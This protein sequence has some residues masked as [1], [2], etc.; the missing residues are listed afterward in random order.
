MTMPNR[1]LDRLLNRLS[2]K[3]HNPW[4]MLALGI[5]VGF[6]ALTLVFKLSKP[7]IK[8]ACVYIL[9]SDQDKGSGRQ[10]RVATIEGATVTMGTMTKRI[11]SVGN[12][13][14]NASVTIRAEMPARIKELPF[15]EG[16]SVKAGQDIIRFE[17][18]DA[19]ADMKQA[20]AQVLLAKADFDRVSKLHDQKIGSVKEFDKGKAELAMAEARL[21]GAKAK[22]DKTVIK[23]S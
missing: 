4:A 2:Q 22:L 15:T 16:G 10:S 1:P 12:L 3:E 23:A 14:A 5:V 19:Q 8:S 17:D 13:K 11:A 21:D 20:E 6:L 9:E 7:I 18:A